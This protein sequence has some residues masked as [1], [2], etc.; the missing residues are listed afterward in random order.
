VHWVQPLEINTERESL[1]ESALHESGLQASGQINIRSTELR[2]ARAVAVAEIDR[3]SG[4][5][6]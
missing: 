4:L 1:A 5:P 3:E 6:R 2:L